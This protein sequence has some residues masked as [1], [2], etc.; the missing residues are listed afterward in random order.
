ME[1]K[2]KLNEKKILKSAEVI[3]QAKMDGLGTI[4]MVVSPDTDPEKIEAFK[5]AWKEEMSKPATFIPVLV[6]WRNKKNGKLYNI[7]TEGTDCTNENPLIEKIVYREKHGLKTW[8]RD[9]K[10][11]YE[12]FEKVSYEIKS[13]D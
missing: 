13:E 3:T 6:D 9:A 8:I 5:K 10:E 12:K 2:T 11:F 7:V 4:S 1:D